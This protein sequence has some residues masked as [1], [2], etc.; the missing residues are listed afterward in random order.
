MDIKNFHNAVIEVKGTPKT[1]SLTVAK[2]TQKR[3]DNILKDIDDLISKCSQDFKLLN[4]KELKRRT[5]T[6]EYRYFEMTKDGFTMLA[7]GYTGKQFIEFKEKYIQ[8][9]NDMENGITSKL[10]AK[11]EFPQL[12]D[13]IQLMHE[14]PKPYHYSNE[15][16]MINRI[17]TGKSAS[18][19]R[20]ENGLEKG[21][22]IRPYLKEFEIE[23][24]LKLQRAD[25]GMVLSI[26]NFEDR[27]YQ[28]KK[29]FSMLRDNKKQLT[30]K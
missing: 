12:T 18:Q 1:T 8:K 22:S 16:D 4:F 5:K 10:L 13:N 14:E 20:K 11:E 25:V 28:L 9:F 24:I 19:I 21:T 7:M 29:Y 6:G 17:V 27:K 15:L 30:L 23:M 2:L 3:H 26:P